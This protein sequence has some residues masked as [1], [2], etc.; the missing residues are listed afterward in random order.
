[1]KP[2]AWLIA[3]NEFV[4]LRFNCDQASIQS[5]ACIATNGEQVLDV[6][7]IPYSGSGE[8]NLI[9]ALLLNS[10]LTRLPCR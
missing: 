10:V 7:S 3:I 1:M 2:Q 9:G 6:F 8:S 4:N 5:G